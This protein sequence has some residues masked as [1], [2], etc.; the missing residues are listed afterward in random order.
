MIRT[1]QIAYALLTLLLTSL[2]AAQGMVLTTFNVEELGRSPGVV[3]LSP[4]FLSIIEFEDAV[5]SAATGRSD[6][7]QTSVDGNSIILRP[8]RSAGS[9]DLIV[10]VGGRTTMFVLRI[11]EANPSPRRYMVT[12]PAPVTPRSSSLDWLQ[13]LGSRNG[14][15]ITEQP[16]AEA[17]VEPAAPAEQ[18]PA[19][20]PVAAPAPEPEPEPE[21][22]AEEATPTENTVNGETVPYEFSTTVDVRSN[23]E[24]VFR[25][26]LRNVGANT[27]VNDNGRL[28]I[29]TN[30]GRPVEYSIIRMNPDGLLNR[31]NPGKT[32]YG[33]IRVSNPPSADLQI[34]WPIVELGPGT[35]HTI[36][37]IVTSID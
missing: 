15:L 11:S 37:E 6:M 7:I 5:Q 16:A 4:N 19:P 1:R 12:S 33:T 34:A 27:I 31:V 20:A 35:T 26:T 23:D 2:V 29:T 10:Q 18:A 13:P 22:V 24:V 21:V 17:P 30:N 28:S 14:G 32:E 25:Y 8:T 9:T 3:E 36:D